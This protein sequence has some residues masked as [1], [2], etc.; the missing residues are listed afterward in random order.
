MTKLAE[1]FQKVACQMDDRWG[2]E[3][4]KKPRSATRSRYA[5]IFRATLLGE[6]EFSQRFE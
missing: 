5:E 6:V 4:Q 2:A 1:R 3:E